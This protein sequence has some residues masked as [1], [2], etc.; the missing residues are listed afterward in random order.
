MATAIKLL[1][2]IFGVYFVIRRE[3]RAFASFVLLL[4][5]TTVAVPA[6]FL[7][8]RTAFALLGEFYQLQVGP[9]LSGE[10][11]HHAIYAR[12]AIRKTQHDQDL[13]ALL[14]RH[15]RPSTAPEAF[16]WPGSICAWYAG[17]VRPVR[18]H[19]R[20]LG[21]DRVAAGRGSGD[22]AADDRPRIR[23]LR[24]AEPAAVAP[25]SMAYWP[26]LMIPWAVLLGR[27]MDGHTPTRLRRLAGFTLGVSAISC[28]LVEV[29]FFRAL[30][31]GFWGQVTLWSGLVAMCHE[32][33]RAARLTSDLAPGVPWRRPRAPRAGAVLEPASHAANEHARVTRR[34]DRSEPRPGP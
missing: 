6:M 18:R 11:T 10:S 31:I 24:D 1:P 23:R 28:V 3:R 7:G 21:G 32:E 22:R 17:D 12:T 20:D 19:P 27:L 9:Y 15:S 26:V 13:G 2:A 5:V 16:S 34:T 33:R 4:T 8:P 29:S 25:Q 14:M 30:T